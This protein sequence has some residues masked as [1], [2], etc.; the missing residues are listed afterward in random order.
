MRV[1]RVKK[2]RLR[3]QI[4][5]LNRRADKAIAVE[6][7]NIQ[8]LEQQEASETIAFDGPSESLA[9]QLSPST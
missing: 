5:L 8:E 4:D 7:G 6:E 2:E 3:Q 1:A 9:L